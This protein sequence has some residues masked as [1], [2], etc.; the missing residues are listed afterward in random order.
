MLDT[1]EDVARYYESA[2]RE[3]SQKDDFPS[4]FAFPRSFSYDLTFGLV[5]RGSR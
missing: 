4:S 5:T 3:K 2:Q 1:I